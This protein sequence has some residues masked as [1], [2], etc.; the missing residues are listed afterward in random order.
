MFDILFS[1][2]FI[3]VGGMLII[4]AITSRINKTFETQKEMWI[5]IIGTFAFLLAIIFFADIYPLNLLLVAIFSALIGWQI[6]PTIEH[7]GKRF[8]MRKYFKSRGVVIKKG[9]EITEEQK[10]EFELSFDVNQYQQ[11]W[12]NV[13]FQAIFATALATFSTAGIVF[14]TSIDFSFLGGFLLISL[15]MLV[16]MGLLN[17]FFF[18][19]KI[20]SLVRAYIG[21]VIFTLYLIYDFDR[22][23]KMAGDESWGTAIDIAVNIYLDIINLFLDLLEILAESN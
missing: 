15:I 9:Q 17:I 18:R 6:G 2:T 20:L 7:F 8:K 21:A 3:I 13:V 16:V 4:T 22:L 19:S 5:T 1:R 23:E 11:E 10:K 14:L 12:H